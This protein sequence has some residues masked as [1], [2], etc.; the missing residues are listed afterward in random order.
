[1][2]KIPVLLSLLIL[3]IS[4]QKP[5]RKG[6]QVT[7]FSRLSD[8][9]GNPPMEYRTQPFWVWN[10][11]VTREIIDERLKD[12]KEMGFGGLFIHPRYGLITEYLGKDWNELVAYAVEKAKTLGLQIWIYDENSFPSGFAGGHVPAEMPESWNEGV[13]VLCS[14]QDKLALDTGT[15]Y[16]QVLKKEK[17]DYV[18]ITVDTSKYR[19]KRGDFVLLS[20]GFFGRSKWYAGY[21]YVDLLKPGVTEKFIDVTM[22]GYEKNIGSEFGKTLSGTFTDEPNTNP[23]ENN[24]IRW[25][26]DFFKQFET[27]CGYDLQ[28]HLLSLF[29]ETGDWQKVRHDYYKTL[30]HL[31]I[32]RWAKPWSEYTQRKDLVWTGHYWEHGWPRFAD[33]PDNMAMY[34][35]FGMPGIDMLFNTMDQSDYPEQFGNIRAVK[36]LASVANQTG[37]RRTLSET[38][39]A[40]GWELTFGDMKRLGEWEYVLGVNFMNQHLSYNSIAGDRKDDF[41]QS[42][43]YHEPWWNDYKSL[44]A[45]FG[46][47]SFALASG[48]QENRILVL[49]P[50][51]TAWM[52]YAPNG[53]NAR[54]EAIRKSFHDFLKILEQNQVEYDLGCENLMKDAGRADSGSMVVG[55]R[56]YELVVLPPYMEN[57]DASTRSLLQR[58]LETGG[59]VMAI[60]GQPVMTEGLEDAS[61]RN[62]PDKFAK[63]W[64]SVPSFPE[65]GAM[66]LLRFPDFQIEYGP[67]GGT[68]LLHMRRNLSDGQLLFLVN[69]SPSKN[70]SGTVHM[71]GQ[72]IRQLDLFSGKISTYPGRMEEGKL[73]FSFKLA[74]GNSLLLFAGTKG[75]LNEDAEPDRTFT[76]AGALAPSVVKNL[77]ENVISLDYCTLSL[78]TL[79]DTTTFFYN[80]GFMVWRKYGDGENPWVSSSQFRTELVDKDTF[81]VGTGFRLNYTFIVQP[82]TDLTAL[83]V[84]AER[85]RI[86]K[87]SVNG[88]AVSALPGQWWLDHTFAVYDIGKL[89]HI[90]VNSIMLTV[91]P[92]SIY[93]EVEPVYVV[94]NFTVK[95]AEKG[96]ELGPLTEM[97]LGSWKQQGFPFY[98]G[99]V[100]YTRKF[101]LDHVPVAGKIVLDKWSGVL[102]EVRVN[103]RDA[104]QIIEKP[105]EKDITGFLV[106]GDNE[107]VV[108][109]CGSLKN[110]LGPLHN[111]SQRGIV[112]PWSFKYA[113]PIQ[114]PGK[115]YDQLDYG[116]VDDVALMISQ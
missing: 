71:E 23:G 69:S 19:G 38:Y 4:C 59:R 66:Q 84:V 11:S 52:Y 3:I 15:Y 105:W 80:A 32:N 51:T 53:E 93:A 41:P 58:Y 25:T 10:D 78:D 37:K 100:S 14:R 47:L 24:A 96:F 91:S 62:L 16:F 39:G 94:G 68:G 70:I 112:T 87:V 109:V 33:G 55:E 64:F 43:S 99:K 6:E 65:D 113:P 31:F 28:P 13:S 102:A 76:E 106:K 36:E 30:L 97:G 57:L 74:P 2:K 20:K 54:V 104:G 79:P 27:L 114:P 7:S 116:L 67:D 101:N 44:T 9:F 92:M 86:F 85:P 8:F 90:G 83:K 1:M 50:T 48:K 88:K 40:A 42:F 89:S 18:D 17:S 46:R 26:P 95:Q 115:D 56:K 34:P 111:V 75:K 63:Q 61:L 103:G 77:Q 72:S 49:E 60:G 45:Y 107:V 12:Y 81:A 108:T 98:P 21:S 22:Q 5:F 82:G 110:L 73:T 29:E 35:Y